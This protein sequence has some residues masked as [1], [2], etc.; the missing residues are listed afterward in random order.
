MLTYFQSVVLGL[1]QGVT[2]LFPVSSLGHSVMIPALLGWT[3][4]LRAQSDPGSFF[5]AFLVG[6]HLATA[7]ALVAFY[8]REWIRITVGFC[9]S[10]RHRRI[11][12]ADERLAWL[13]IAATVPTAILALLFER[14][15][16]ELFAKPIF[17]SI[18]LV[19]NGLVLLS[20]EALS[21]RARGKA[22]ETDGMETVKF[23]QAGLIGV[24]QTGALLAGISRS[25]ISLVGGLFSGLSHRA[26]ARFSFLLATPI[27][28]LAG[29]Y[30]VPEL[31]GPGGNGVRGQIA[32][33]SLAAGIS[34]YASIRFLDRY[35]Q[36][37][38]T[39]PYAAY[40][41]VAGCLATVRFLMRS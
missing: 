35:F 5:L 26:A 25:G 12:D 41:L 21:R 36:D 34:A 32:V 9:T 3:D 20:S 17:A 7:L 8:R 16:R 14:P 6:L 15:I 38:T 40:C 24:F 31:L 29:V 18:F 30:K 28:L 39:R 11:S 27:I 4:L 13:L 10:I 37:R 33:G 19:V 2:E 22:V 23:R 1:L